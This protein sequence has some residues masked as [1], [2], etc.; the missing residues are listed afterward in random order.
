M[1]LKNTMRCEYPNTLLVVP[2]QDKLLSKLDESE[3]EPPTSQDD[4][5]VICIHVMYH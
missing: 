3:P 4:E 1:L 5:C 2:F